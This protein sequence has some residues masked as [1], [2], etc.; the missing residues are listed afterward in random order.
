MSVNGWF[1]LNVTYNVY[2]VHV[3]IVCT[4]IVHVHIVY[5]MNMYI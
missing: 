3:H 1:L 5:T 4:I 2:N